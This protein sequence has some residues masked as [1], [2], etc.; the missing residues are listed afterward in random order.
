MSGF[1]WW[2]PIPWLLAFGSLV[3]ALVAYRRNRHG[4]LR[5][6]VWCSGYFQ[7]HGEPDSHARLHVNLLAKGADVYDIR[8]RL[9]CVDFVWVRRHRSRW[10]PRLP[11]R[12]QHDFDFTPT[13]GGFSA[14]PL[15][16]PNPLKNGQAVQSL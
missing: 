12:V 7:S 3:V 4:T 15:T 9:E 13:A 5:M 2:T 1:P 8:V 11:M 10:S 14:E 16:H 6:R